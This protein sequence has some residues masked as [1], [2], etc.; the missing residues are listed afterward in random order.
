MVPV[1]VSPVYGRS[2][3]DASSGSC[4]YS[5]TI[6]C[7]DGIFLKM[8]IHGLFIN[9]NFFTLNHA[10]KARDKPRSSAYHT[11]RQLSSTG[12]VRRFFVLFCLADPAARADRASQARKKIAAV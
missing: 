7:M 3:G 1:Y 6:Y 12:F 11:R 10:Y 2:S 5:K 9:V 8:R 4:A